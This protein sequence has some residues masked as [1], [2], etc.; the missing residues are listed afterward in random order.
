MAD[1]KEL[2]PKKIGGN[3]IKKRQQKK[4]SYKPMSQSS[5]YLDY[6]YYNLGAPYPTTWRGNQ[7][8]LGICDSTSGACYTELMKTKDQI[9]DTFQRF[10]H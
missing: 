9:F 6:L 3:Y 1:I 7:F 8:Y 5:E 10:I 4:P 2:I